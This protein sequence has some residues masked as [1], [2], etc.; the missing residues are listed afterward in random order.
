[1]PALLNEVQIWIVDPGFDDT[2]TIVPVPGPAP[3][4]KGHGQVG[5]T[6][7]VPAF[8][9][10]YIDDAIQDH[11]WGQR[12]WRWTGRFRAGLDRDCQ[13]GLRCAGN[14]DWIRCGQRSLVGRNEY[15]LIGR[16]ESI[17]EACFQLIDP[18]G[19][20]VINR[21]KIIQQDRGDD[22]EGEEQ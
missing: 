16:V 19:D 9:L 21:R 18:P 15:G 20:P 17:A 2:G 4:V 5:W 6:A 11:A 14:Q 10:V 1:M 12:G 7:V 3:E 22:E 8:V 13:G